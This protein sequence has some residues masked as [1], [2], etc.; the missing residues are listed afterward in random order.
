MRYLEQDAV[1]YPGRD[2][3][4]TDL[5]LESPYNTYLYRGLPPGPIANPGLPS[6]Q[7]AA[8]P[9]DTQFMFFVADG[10]GGHVFTTGY[11][12]HLTAT[13]QLRRLRGD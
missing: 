12:E 11:Q 9:A 10:S 1:G 8:N 7:A 6:L 4:L 3:T 5:A 2:L 13:E